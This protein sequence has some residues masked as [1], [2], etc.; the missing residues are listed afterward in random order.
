MARNT[1]PL[2]TKGIYSLRTP[3]STLQDTLYECIAVRSFADFVNRG[4]DV[5][6][7]YYAP[8]GETEEKYRADLAEGAHIV[9][10]ASATSAMIFVPDTYIEKFPDLSGVPYK[11]IVAAVLIGPLPDSVD[12]EH[13]KAELALTASD[14]T[15]VVSTADIYAAPYSGVMTAD[16]HATHEAARQAAITNRTIDRAEVVRLQALVDAQ[17]VRIKALEQIIRDQNGQGP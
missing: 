4:E 1:P 16:E 5:F 2:H 9:T 3:Y 14:I 8:K 11:R 13:L 15:G 10:L 12:M 6:Q 7:K 17:A